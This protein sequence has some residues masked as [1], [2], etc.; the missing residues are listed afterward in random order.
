MSSACNQVT[1]VIH[2]YVQF[3]KLYAAVVDVCNNKPFQYT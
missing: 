3:I 2:V 1:E